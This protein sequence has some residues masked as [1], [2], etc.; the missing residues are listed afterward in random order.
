MK[1]IKSFLEEYPSGHDYDHSFIYTFIE[2]NED[3]EMQDGVTQE[4]LDELKNLIK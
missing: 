1:K 4:I 3:D 2:S